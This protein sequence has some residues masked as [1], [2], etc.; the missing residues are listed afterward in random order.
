MT[1]RRALLA[2]VLVLALVGGACSDDGVQRDEATNELTRGGSLSVYE[3][4]ENDC[5]LIEEPPDPETGVEKVDAV[6]CDEEHTHEVYAVDGETLPERFA[7]V[8]PGAPDLE[9][10]ANQICFAEFSTFV[11]SDVIDSTLAFTYLYPTLDSW[12]DT[13]IMDREIVCLVVSDRRTG[14]VEGSGL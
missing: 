12:S 2:P 11:E 4:L 1:P 3:L 8:Y 6:P 13:D 14:S 5:I 9:A 10:V 7:D